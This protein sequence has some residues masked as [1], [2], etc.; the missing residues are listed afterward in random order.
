MDSSNESFTQYIITELN[1]SSL[2]ESQLKALIND[3][4]ANI[5]SLSQTQCFEISNCVIDIF[6]NDPSKPFLCDLFDVWPL[7]T[8]KVSTDDKAYLIDRLCGFK[9]PIHSIVRICSAL[10]EVSFSFEECVKAINKIEHVILSWKSSRSLNSVDLEELPALFYQLTSIGKSPNDRNC[11]NNDEIMGNISHKII[12][13]VTKSLDSLLCDYQAIKNNSSTNQISLYNAILATIVHH[14]TLVISKDQILSR[15]IVNIFK[16]RD[17][18]SIKIDKSINHRQLNSDSSMVNSISPSLLVL[19]LLV[20]K[21]PRQ[22]DK[23]IQLIKDLI[24]DSYNIL[25]VSN[26]AEFYQNK[27]WKIDDYLS[28]ENIKFSFETLVRGPLMVESLIKPL[29]NLALLIIGI[30]IQKYIYIFL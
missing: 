6:Q 29:L 19:L 1:K 18:D 30:N 26:N 24:I 15:E 8:V 5:H 16:L 10:V 9:W 7:I 23:I 11:E 25:D 20:T 22:E 27:M 2:I 14:L 12:V 4:F 28:F 3:L 17:F 21:S 13:S